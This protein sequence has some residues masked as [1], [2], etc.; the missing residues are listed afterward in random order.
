[1]IP[2]SVKRWFKV[3]VQGKNVTR[4]AP[5]TQVFT[6]A[7]ILGEIP[8]QTV[9]TPMLQDAQLWDVVRDLRGPAYT[10]PTGIVAEVKNGLF[11]PANRVLLGP[12]RTVVAESL[13]TLI[14]SET[15]TQPH[16]PF[17]GKFVFGPIEGRI[18][19]VSTTFQFHRRNYYHTLVDALPRLYLLHQMAETPAEQPVHIL[20]GDLSRTEKQYLDLLRPSNTEVVHLSPGRVVETERFLHLSFLSRQSVGFLPASYLSF[21]RSKVLPHRPPTQAKRVLVTRQVAGTRR[22]RNLD[23]VWAALEPLGFERY[24]LETLSAS[25]QVELFYDAE[26]VVATHGASLANLLFAGPSCRVVELFPHA[27]VIPTYYL[28]SRALG[29]DYDYLCSTQTDRYADFEVDVSRLQ[30]VLHNC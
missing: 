14:G 15:P 10:S 7:S 2:D 13:S 6:E 30:A 24:E 21:F 23:A 29:L 22:I 26:V 18:P 9:S 20:V 17:R 8:A 4:V 11:C 16:Y 25:E 12:D 1:M 27:F 28:M 5:L 3:H 19:G